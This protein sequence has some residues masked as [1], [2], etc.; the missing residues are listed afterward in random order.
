LTTA[1]AR[2]EP[3][4]AVQTE[5]VDFGV[6]FE[7]EHLRLGRAI[8]LLVGDRAEAEELVQEALARAYERWDRVSRM[9]EP[10]GYVYRIAANLHRRRARARRVVDRIGEQL[11]V[12]APSD[13]S[14]IADAR[15][16]LFAALDALPVN[17]RAALI[18]VELFGYDTETV[19]L[20]LGIKPV[21]VR[22]RVHRAR[23]LLRQQLGGDE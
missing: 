8:Y 16:D 12:Q 13:P 22:V 6:F 9:A 14:Q 11:R 18:L 2:T 15:V 7:R 19:A 21:S 1:V 3:V 5:P 10:A 17:Q 20:I 23:L 4:I